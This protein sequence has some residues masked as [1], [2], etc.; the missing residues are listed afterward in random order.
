RGELSLL[1]VV[2]VRRTCSAPSQLT[3]QISVSRLSFSAS[4]APMVYAIHLPSGETCGSPTALIFDKSS[5]AIGRLDDWALSEI[6]ASKQKMTILNARI[7]RCS[8][9]PIGLLLK[10]RSG[11][12]CENP[13]PSP[14]ESRTIRACEKGTRIGGYDRGGGLQPPCDGEPH[15]D[16][17]RRYQVD[18]PADGRAARPGDLSAIQR[19]RHRLHDGHDS[20]S[21]AGRHHGR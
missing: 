8:L 20:A 14:V 12:A 9:P 17:R 4:T 6:A 3:I 21:R 5:T 7:M 19:C 10:P 1:S 15:P 16:K 11:F 13:F 2:E 18:P